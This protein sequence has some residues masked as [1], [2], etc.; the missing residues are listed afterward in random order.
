[1]GF[2]SS[3]FPLYLTSVQFL[4][5][6]PSVIL[7]NKLS[8][9]TVAAY[10]P[11]LLGFGSMRVPIADFT[12]PDIFKH[13]GMSNLKLGLKTYN[14]VGDLEIFTSEPATVHPM[15]ITCSYPKYECRD[16]IFCLDLGS[17]DWVSPSLWF[18]NFGWFET[19]TVPPTWS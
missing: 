18:L 16:N 9:L 1:M 6:P 4:K 7:L 2:F 15:N 3:L 14:V 11:E 19:I 13:Q 8:M 12:C 17:P 5:Q 10:R